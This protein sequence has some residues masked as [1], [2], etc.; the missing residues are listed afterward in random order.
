MEYVNKDNPFPNGRLVT[1]LPSAQI[2]DEVT[3][4]PIEKE[5]LKQLNIVTILDFFKEIFSI[6]RTIVPDRINRIEGIHGRSVDAILVALYRAG[7]EHNIYTDLL[8][9]GCYESKNVYH[10]K[11]ELLGVKQVRQADISLREL[12]ELLKVTDTPQTMFLTED[13]ADAIEYLERK[14]FVYISGIDDYI[15]DGIDPP[16]KTIKNLMKTSLLR[17]N[18]IWEGLKKLGYELTI[19][20][21]PAEGKVL[22]YLNSRIEN[23]FNDIRP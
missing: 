12:L 3:F 16:Q 8:I 11:P 5:R 22:I 21:E 10:P 17:A 13:F 18:D 6:Y 4:S 20:K 1:T 9:P 23:V 19:H 7:Y 15:D 14:G 2:A